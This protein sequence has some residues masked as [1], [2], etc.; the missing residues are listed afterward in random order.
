MVNY[1]TSLATLTLDIDQSSLLQIII[2]VSTTCYSILPYHIEPVADFISETSIN[3]GKGNDILV[4]RFSIC[5]TYRNNLNSFAREEL[6]IWGHCGRR[7]LELLKNISI[8][9]K[10]FNVLFIFVMI[11]F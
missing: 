6:M 11:V 2:I 4:I 5:Y 10:L 1:Y 9:G 3:T 8:F 7:L